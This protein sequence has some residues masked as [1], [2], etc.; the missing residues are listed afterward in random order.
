[1]GL[2]PY[3]EPRYANLIREQLVDIRDDGSIQLDTS[4]FGFLASPQMTNPRFEAIFGGPARNAESRITRREMDIAASIQAVTEDVVLKLVAH[5]VK[6]T[7]Y[8][9]VAMAGCV[10]LNCV[11]N[12]KVLR[13]SGLDGLFVQPAAGDA[14]GALGAALLASHELFGAP[15][16][17][18]A[19]RDSLS[20]SYLGPAFSK[21]EVEDFVD[22]TDAPNHLIEDDDE[23][24]RVVADALADGNVVGFFNGRMEFGP[25][26]TSVSRYAGSEGKPYFTVVANSLD[27]VLKGSESLQR[28]DYYEDWPKTHFEIVV[29]RRERMARRYGA[30]EEWGDR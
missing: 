22:R 28:T 16:R 17:V 1:M 25:R 30:P 26:K 4:A 24:A 29:Q 14:G 23:R 7:G 9:S 10:A 12:G 18:T 2:A 11:A 5:A 6:L 27:A 20:G 13:A 3:G 15:R 21:Y 8:N 19:G